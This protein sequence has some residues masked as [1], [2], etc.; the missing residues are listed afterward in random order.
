MISRLESQQGT[1]VT[2]CLDSQ[3][4]DYQQARIASRH[5]SHSQAEEP[6]TGMISKIEL[7]QGSTATHILES[8]GQA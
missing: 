4:Q 5:H 2:H 7:Q 1:T 8:Q 3:R 6:R